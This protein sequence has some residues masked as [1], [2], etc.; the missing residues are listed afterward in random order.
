MMRNMVQT[1][2]CH[3]DYPRCETSPPT[4]VVRITKYMTYSSSETLVRITPDVKRHRSFMLSGL[5]ND[6]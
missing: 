5:R 2:N 6:M 1:I 3:P 4:F